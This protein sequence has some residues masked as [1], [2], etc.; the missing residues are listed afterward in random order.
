MAP[1]VA[2]LLIAPAAAPD[3]VD[4]EYGMV[5]RPIDFPAMEAP[6]PRLVGIQSVGPPKGVPTAVPTAVSGNGSSGTDS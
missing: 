3:H 4:R 2:L 5:N 1:L 6:R